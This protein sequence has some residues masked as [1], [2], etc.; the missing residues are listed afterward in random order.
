MP[1]FASIQVFVITKNR[2]LYAFF[3]VP[4]VSLQKFKNKAI[5]RTSLAAVWTKHTV[6]NKNGRCL[7]KS[8]RNE[9]LISAAGQIIS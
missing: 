5:L 9:K 8:D 3:S 2:F 1:S 6:M 7:D 4:S